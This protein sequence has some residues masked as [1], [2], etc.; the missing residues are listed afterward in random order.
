VDD[1]QTLPELFEDIAGETTHS[2]KTT[3][4]SAAN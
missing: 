3:D 2:E 1:A 4:R